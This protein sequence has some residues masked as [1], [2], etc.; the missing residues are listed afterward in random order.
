MITRQSD[1]DRV[2]TKGSYLFPEMRFNT[3][4]LQITESIRVILKMRPNNFF[5]DAGL[6]TWAPIAVSAL[7]PC[8]RHKMEL[9]TSLK[10]DSKLKNT[11][12]S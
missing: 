2:N 12:P 9:L 3:Q 8:R 7:H 11:V 1:G 6:W 5:R 4:G 10:L